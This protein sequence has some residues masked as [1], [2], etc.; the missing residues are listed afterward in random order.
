M[1]RL[2]TSR[3]NFAIPVEAGTLVF[4]SKTGGVSLL[5]GRDQLV[6]GD[7]LCGVPRSFDSTLLIETLLAELSRN[8]ILVPEGHDELADIRS[9]YLNAKENAP[10]VMTITTTMDCNL[11]CYYCYEER[12]TD[13]LEV[14]DI[15]RLL[16]HVRRRLEESKSSTLHVDWYGG[17]P[18]LNAEF[19][20][21][22][23]PKLQVL[24]ADHNIKYSASVI[25]NGTAWPADVVAF[26]TRHA[27][28][29]VQISFDGLRE[30]HNRRR[31]YRKRTPDVGQSSFDEAVQLV[32][33][34]VQIVRVDARINIDAENVSDVAPLLDFM[35]SRGWFDG[36]YPVFVQPARLAS[37]S[38]RSAFM[39]KHE[40]DV[41]EY[42]EIRRSVRDRIGHLATVEESESPDGYPWP[43][44]SV[45]AALA[46]HSDVVGADG[47][48]YKCGL[49]V[50]ERQR[51]IESLPSEEKCRTSSLPI[52]QQD[53]IE[54]ATDKQ[55]WSEFDPTLQP[56]C[57]KCSFLPV[58]WGGCPKKHLEGDSHALAEQGE[59]WRRN[60]ARLVT[61]HL[62]FKPS[63]HIF[64]DADQFRVRTDCIE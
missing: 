51:R 22:A 3:Y 32:D 14:A 5:T 1:T 16:K 8:G 57:S 21:N 18:L 23:S 59:Y 53:E 11:G 6:L 40:L 43:R 63:T 44:T 13:R 62:G 42:D 31:R 37:Y 29:Q 28:R 7:L 52:L 47:F 34:L 33:K 54:A 26:I 56:T 35:K 20:D 12:S 45:C 49:Q 41:Q 60:L 9:S 19:I 30:N 4:C 50:S 39:R 10:L 36:T 24:C 38:D 64:S 61:H 58:C 27:I 17:E 55:F 2:Q 15:S 25:S 48:L 46:T